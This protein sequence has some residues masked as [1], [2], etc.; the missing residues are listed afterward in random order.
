MSW[1][2][3]DEPMNFVYP[4]S[5]MKT[6]LY[7]VEN[8]NDRETARRLE[9]ALLE[10]KGVERVEANQNMH[11][12]SVTHWDELSELSIVKRLESEGCPLVSPFHSSKLL[13]CVFM[14]T[15]PS[16]N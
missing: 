11:E 7:K 9:H 3:S 6:T 13:S 10:I 1:F 12:V 2:F 16:L 5:V 14:P 4:T 15:Y 8:L